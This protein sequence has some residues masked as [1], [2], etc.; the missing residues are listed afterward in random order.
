VSLNSGT[1]IRLT[2]WAAAGSFTRIG[3]TAVW[4]GTADLG[5]KPMRRLGICLEDKSPAWNL[6]E[7]FA[8][9]R[10]YPLLTNFMAHLLNQLMV[11]K[12]SQNMGKFVCARGKTGSSF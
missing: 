12:R 7:T 2:V 9:A 4:S 1:K 11:I 10:I 3:V 8:N 6:T 5:G